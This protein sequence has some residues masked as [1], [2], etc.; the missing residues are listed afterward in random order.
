[1]NLFKLFLFR[2]A[3]NK[4]DFKKCFIFSTIVLLFF[5]SACQNEDIVIQVT[6]SRC[7]NRINPMG[8]DVRNPHL[9]WKLASSYRN[10]KQSAYQ[11]LVANSKETLKNNIGNLWDTKKVTS[12]QSIQVKYEGGQLKSE[13][14][15]YW[16]VRVWDEAGNVSNWSESALWEMGLLNKGDSTKWQAEWINDG[17]QSPQNLKEF[18]EEDPAPLF[19]YEFKTK[20][21][22]KKAR[23]YI[24]GLGYYEATINSKKVGDNV[25]D[26]GWTNYSKRI[27]YSTYDVTDQIENIGNC[28]GVTLGNG[29][30]NPLPMTMWGWLN[31]RE[32]LPI[33]RPQFIAQLK[34]E[35]EDGMIK[36]VISNEEWKTHEGPILRNNIYLGEVYDA[37]KEIDDW[38]T[39]GF[40][41]SKW[42]Y[43]KIVNEKIGELEAQNQP[44]IRI[45][46]TLKPVELM[47]PKPNVYIFDMGQNFAGWVKLKVNAPKGTKINLRYG[48]LLNKDGTLNVMTSVAGQVKGSL[49]G[50]H[51]SPDT[52]WQSDTYIA[53]GKSIEYYTPRF[54][55]HG[56]RYVEVT[57]Y[58]GKPEI[59]AV[60]GLRLNSDLEKVGSFECSNK[61]FNDIQK[62]TEWTFL[63]NVFSVQSDCPHRE[64]FG[65]GGDIAT[66][67]DAF[68]YNF[69]MS[70]FY[71]KVAI[72]FQ[73]AALPDGRLRDNAPFTGADYCGIGWAV[74]HPVILLKLYQY[75][76][77]ISL[78]EE[79][80][81]TARKW[82]DGVISNN[83]LIITE[84][85]S[86]HE[87][88]AP[89]PKPEMV[90]PLYY[91]SALIMSRLAEI[92]NKFDDAERYKNLSEQIKKAYLEKFHDKGT[93]KF[94]PYTQGSQSFALYTGLTPKEEIDFA[95]SQLVKDI[96]DHDGHI[97]TGLY[98]TKFSLDILSKYGEAETAAQMVSKK[99]FPGWGNMLE[100]GATTLWE[101]WEY[102]D[103]T[104]SHNHPM[105]GVVSEWFYKWVAGIQSDTSAVGFD[106]IV[107]RPQIISNVD[108]A[109]AHFNSV[110]GKI[111]CEWKRDDDIFALDVTI[112]AN[113]TATIY[114]PTLEK[115]NVM[116]GDKL[117]SKSEGVKFIRWDG[118][119]AVFEIGSGNYSFSSQG[120]KMNVTKPYVST[121]Q[122]S[123]DTKILM[124]GDK[125]KAEIK[126]KEN[127]AVIRYTLDGSEPNSSSQIYNKPLIVTNNITII[128][129]AFLDGFKPSIIFKM[130]Y[131]FID[132]HKNGVN[133]DF[134]EG[135]FK[136]LPDFKE[137]QPVKN[138]EVFQ[139][140]LDKIDLPQYNFALQLNSYIK[141]DREGEYEFS[142]SS[143]DGSK[144]YVNGKLIVDNDGEHGSRQLSGS[145]YLTK[146]KHLICV[147]YFQ[148][149]GGKSL[150]LFYWSDKISFQLI[151]GSVLFKSKN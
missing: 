33:G 65:W 38:N 67:T 59:D 10:K 31:L 81:E 134:Y 106:K 73:D 121:P 68:I 85:L 84:G 102:S 30:Y 43:A 66:T 137:L 117:A 56:F 89:R 103:N 130:S 36:N 111:I 132:P 52:A 28:I 39:F 16:K 49:I 69:N 77:N 76:G 104:F 18:Y 53:K 92:I 58:P 100:K 74:A 105:F 133:W 86:D 46:K 126:C 15:Y 147:E 150:Q 129:K 27:L 145:I 4:I 116:E 143:N 60:E 41:D 113:T 140:G 64:R 75:Y 14:I 142:I 34:I 87:S 90:T 135:R 50:G 82:F 12:I 99:D 54:T 114:V 55:F 131:D 26:P 79:Q 94:A 101:H 136:V 112:P 20:K 149:G 96:N 63:S 125:V 23:L 118:N 9:S 144:L 57:G 80:Y 61:L 22:I 120:T 19:R 93:G 51:Y 17:K 115:E 62:M 7:E 48:E 146:G 97:T 25:L 21:E 5:I 139:F 141:I 128:A 151:P 138:G 78:I 35:F 40:D 47:E 6:S 11:I 24:S 29:W 108:W 123:K 2:Q 122:I 13:M 72:D 98:G 107:I 119:L 95:V 3:G 109:K 8:I 148:S 127:E 110:H 71:T 32:Y 88:L 44:P 83:D 42:R 45:T 91:Q 37:R 1:M 70:N 124:I